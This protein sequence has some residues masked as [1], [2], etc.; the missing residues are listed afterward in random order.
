MPRVSGNAFHSNAGDSP[1]RCDPCICEG[2]WY[3]KGIMARPALSQPGVGYSHPTDTGYCRHNLR[4]AKL[5][6]LTHVLKYISISIEGCPSWTNEK[7][8]GTV[9]I[10]GSLSSP[11]GRIKH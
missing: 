8:G 10:D 5:L 9:T 2:Q 4:K 7:E 11:R 6:I 3:V 1:L